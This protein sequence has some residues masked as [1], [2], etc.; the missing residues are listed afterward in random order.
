M[1][2]IGQLIAE[3]DYRSSGPFRVLIPIEGKCVSF[4]LGNYDKY[5]EEIENA[6]TKAFNYKW[7]NCGYALFEFEPQDQFAYFVPMNEI[8]RI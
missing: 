3:H 6:A 8:K 5:A 4:L 2:S 7:D 1:L